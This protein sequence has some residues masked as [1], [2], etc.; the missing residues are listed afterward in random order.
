[1]EVNRPKAEEKIIKFW[2][3]NQIFEK[4][5]EKN[6]GDFVFYEG[7]PTANAKPGVHHVL[8]R[9]Y[10]DMICRYKTMKGFRVLRKAGWDIHG[11]PVEISVEKQIGLKNKKDIEEYGINKFNQECKKS[12]W[13]YAQ[14]W[15][16][17]TERIGFWLDLKNPYITGDPLYMESV[18]NI[19]KQISDKGLL[20][21]DY[22][23]MPYCPRC[24]TG[25]SSHEVSQGYKKV[26]EPAIYVKFEI[27]NS[28]FKIDSK[29]KTQNSKFYLLVWTTTPWTL[30]GNVAIAIN[31]KITYILARVGKEYLIVAK[32]RKE[33]LGDD[34]KA[35][36]E[37]NG[38]E[39][40]GLS[41]APLFDQK[42]VS[43]PKEVKN[44]YKVI[45]ADFVTIEEGT[46]LVHIAPAFGQD[47][48]ELIKCQTPDR[49]FPILLSVDEEGKFKPE[50]KKWAGMFVKN[51]DPLII[52][53]LEENGSLF[54]EQQYEHDYPFC[55]RCGTP[56]LYYAKKSWF[57][58]MSKI[59][60]KI[61][62]NNQKINW[63]P[64]HIKEG[65]FGEWL[66][67]LK[68][69]ALSRERYWGTPLPIW[70][71]EKC[72]H[73]EVIGSR[74]NLL[75]QDFSNNTF[76]TLRHG[77]AFS[78][79]EEFYC[80][81]PELR[82]SLL[83]KKGE[84]EIQKIAQKIKQE[85]ID[86]IFS[87]DVLRTS[88]T[89]EIVAKALDRKIEYDP[90]LRE[91]NTGIFNGKEMQQGREF[92][93]PKAM[94]S[95]KEV[96]LNKFDNGFTK[97]ENFSEVKSR[98]LDFVKEIDKK[99]KNKK[100][101][102]ISHEIPI[103]MLKS[104]FLGWTKEK[105]A[106]CKKEIST[107]TGTF[108]KVDLKLFP[109][110]EKGELDFHRPYIDEVQ[111]LCPKCSKLMK[112]VPE[113]I[114]CWFDS[115]AMPFAQ[116]HW[117]F[118][119]QSSSINHNSEPPELFPADYISEAIDQTRGWFYTLL[120]ISTLLGFES[121]YKNV[122]V[123]GHVLDEKSQKM[124]K[125]K[126]NVIDPW[127]M[128]KKYGADAL[129]WYCF[130]INQPW[131][132]KLFNEKDLDQRLK[133]FIMTFWNCYAFWNTYHG[134]SKISPSSLP[135]TQRRGSPVDKNILDKWILSRL[136]G[137]IQDTTES[138]EEYDITGAARAIEGFVID[139]L[140]LWHIRRSRKRF[141]KPETI[142][143]LEQA[144]SVLNYVLLS[145]T[146]IV[147]PFAPFISEEIYL[148]LT[149]KKFKPS[150]HLDD[151][152]EP[153]KKLIDKEL[154]AKMQ[155]ARDT[156]ALGLKIRNDEKIRVRQPLKKLKVKSQKLKGEEE[157]LGLIREELNVKEVEVIDKVEKESGWV[158]EG[159]ESLKI[160][161]NTEITVELQEEGAVREVTRQIQQMR[162]SADCKPRDKIII[163]YSGDKDLTTLLTRNKE[164][165]L[166]QVIVEDLILGRKAKQIFNIEK[167][168]KVDGQNLW[169][170]LKIV[171]R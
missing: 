35:I 140:S 160:S 99:F 37:F 49:E 145:L 167:E 16:Q 103:M 32:E 10:K 93:N 169:L 71:C 95:A 94:L 3:E 41:Y 101:L 108:D 72:E 104:S 56:L 127:E 116:G 155:L 152:P 130:S 17:L 142:N 122:I 50:V 66:N 154:E 9:A 162:K 70:K 19:I 105:T 27:Q 124:S 144:S 119:D 69:W 138:L 11:L 48:M 139:D 24:G 6:G 126:G 2:K 61:I 51:A 109:Y 106:E 129:R 150:V 58:K 91:I 123:L 53:H 121:P 156:V 149:N 96:F 7:P 87:S 14:D 40:I 89:A 8:A 78:N 55:W 110:N 28:K 29:L 131:D 4:S 171:V 46:G 60:K 88:Q 42:V 120:A 34:F 44:I 65:R 5:L 25:L 132:P 128:I 165:V 114:D 151:W 97:G 85:K 117:P 57:I 137:L 157:F 75:E 84:A 22:K 153:D 39:L 136:N 158:V 43:I 77:E 45:P 47:D 52:K 100:I 90:R 18:F 82:K 143:E 15:T 54:K 166:S 81:W 168:F 118:N 1:M 33:V 31:P 134:K 146:R 92:F 112:R 170:G 20:Y 148:G 21:E 135:T 64:A 38:K 26:K 164:L 30:P 12:V 59:K 79:A 62:D 36:K 133:K 102:I 141:Q 83:T 23:V 161:L 73:Q 80:S 159:N 13:Q 147:A 111:F 115:G 74:Q 63:M 107:P 125:S 113:V 67:G 98:V 68:D 163:Y 86:L 76:F